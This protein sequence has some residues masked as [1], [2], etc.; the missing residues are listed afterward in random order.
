MYFQK[1]ITL[2]VLWLGWVIYAQL[3]LTFIL[4]FSPRKV[5]E[6]P[7][8]KC[9]APNC[10]VSHFILVNDQLNCMC[11]TLNFQPHLEGRRINKSFVTS[12]LTSLQ[13]QRYHFRIFAL[14]SF[15]VSANQ[16]GEKK[17]KHLTASSFFLDETDVIF[18]SLWPYGSGINFYISKQSRA[19]SGCPAAA[20]S[21]RSSARSSLKR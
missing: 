13:W 16:E 10:T 14:F 2:H 5:T 4:F 21:P 9:K 6:A 7:R 18:C 12:R 19:V 15:A 20:T 8:N 1:C 17:K 3:E 11:R